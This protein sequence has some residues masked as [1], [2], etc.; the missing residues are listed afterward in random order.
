MTTGAL[1]WRFD[2][3]DDS[4]YVSSDITATDEDSAAP[5]GY[6]SRLFFG[7]NKG[8]LWKLDPSAPSGGVVNAIGSIT[9]DEGASDPDPVTAQALFS[10]RQTTGALGEDRGISGTLI[11]VPDSAPI[12]WSSTSAPAAP[13]RRRPRR[14]TSSTPSMATPATSAPR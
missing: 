1:V 3:G 7:D 2:L 9:I 4:T 6:I 13:P 8:R 11:A 10:T 14:R 5:D 12:G